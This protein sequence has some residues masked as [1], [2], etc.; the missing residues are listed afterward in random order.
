MLSIINT[1]DSNVQSHVVHQDYA[2]AD[3]LHSNFCKRARGLGLNYFWSNKFNEIW[4]YINSTLLLI[5]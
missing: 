5:L 2:R 1:A 3:R 4:W